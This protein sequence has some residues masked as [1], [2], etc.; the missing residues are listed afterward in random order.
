VKLSHECY[1]DISFKTGINKGSREVFDMASNI[2]LKKGGL[3]LSTEA[4]GEPVSEQVFVN[5]KLVGE[6]PFS[7]SVPLCARIEVGKGRETVNVKIRHNMAEKYMHKM[8]TE[9]RRRRLAEEQERQEQAVKLWEEQQEKERKEREEL[10]LFKGPHFA[11]AL[12]P[13]FMMKYIHP[14]YQNNG[15]FLN[16]NFEFMSV[17]NGHLHFGVDA[18]IGNFDID[19]DKVDLSD[20]ENI[21]EYW[22]RGGALTKLYFFDGMLGPYLT[23]GTGWY[24]DS[25]S[26]SGPSF[27]VGAGFYFA[28][29]AE[30]RYF[31][32]PT[33]GRNAGYIA[34]NLGGSIPYGLFMEKK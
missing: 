31:V 29:L 5:G 6:T 33:N 10:A 11:F 4:D 16:F 27:S 25:Y 20:E 32:M 26:Y 7:G 1:E 2:A 13:T 34:L 21:K 8:N 14:A 17:A 15:G 23:A 9:E 19:K 12:G 18:D 30:V 28:F 22:F 24:K 3:V